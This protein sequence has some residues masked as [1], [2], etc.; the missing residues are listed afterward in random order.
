MYFICKFWQY[1]LALYN[2]LQL[3]RYGFMAH[4]R[5]AINEIL[6]N[7][8]YPQYHDTILIKR[9]SI[10]RIP[11]V[12]TFFTKMFPHKHNSWGETWTTNWNEWHVIERIVWSIAVLGI[13]HQSSSYFQY[14]RINF[15]QWVATVYY[16]TKTFHFIWF[17]LFFRIL[18]CTSFLFFTIYISLS[19]LFSLKL[20]II[21][22]TQHVYYIFKLY[23]HE[24]YL[25]SILIQYFIWIIS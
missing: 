25:Y 15:T 23:F 2:Y 9:A 24:R 4:K 11:K 16:A 22:L 18:K 21:L 8:C 10:M 3:L 13:A 5:K 17:W 7:A 20:F 19:P 14:C 12:S 6:F 1:I